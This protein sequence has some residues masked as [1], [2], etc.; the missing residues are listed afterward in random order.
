[1][2]F[3]NIY[4]EE[5]E[6]YYH[7]NQAISALDED[8]KKDIAH[9]G[10]YFGKELN[11]ILNL[12]DAFVSLSSHNDEDYG[13][14]VAEA[15]CTGLPCLLSDWG[16]YSSFKKYSSKGRVELLSLKL[17]NGLF[18]FDDKEVLTKMKKIRKLKHSRKVYG[19]ESQ[20]VL[21]I[22]AVA[23]KLKVIS[24]YKTNKFKGFSSKLKTLTTRWRSGRAFHDSKNRFNS[25]YRSLYATYFN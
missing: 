21:S 15:L 11:G 9:L 2:P 7:Y 17:E 25:Y 24:K 1:M 13:M 4:Q 18:N 8:V 20:R 5:H 22:E 19:Q 6:Y 16:G 14:A 3:L 23:K 10:V 12:A